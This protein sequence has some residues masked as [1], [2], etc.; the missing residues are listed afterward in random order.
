MK[1]TTANL[2]PGTK[3]DV[4]FW[5]SELTGFGLRIRRGAGDRLIRN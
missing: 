2:D 5:D 1:L 3:P 4:I